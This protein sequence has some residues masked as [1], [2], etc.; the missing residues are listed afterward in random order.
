MRTLRTL[1]P[2][3]RGT[4]KLLRQHGSSLLRVRYRYDEEAREHLNTVEL[5]V[6]RR[7]RESEV[8]CSGSRKPGSRSAADAGRS[9]ALRVGWREKGLRWRVKSAGGR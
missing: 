3:Q 4:M 2:G 7:R 1:K 9:V 6:Q 8:E 5:V